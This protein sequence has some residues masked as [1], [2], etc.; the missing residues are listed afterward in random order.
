MT[1]VQV[2]LAR[3]LYFFA[4][5]DGLIDTDSCETQTAELELDGRTYTV[6]HDGD[7]IAVTRDDGEQLDF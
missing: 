6:L 7:G 4:T 1:P 2:T 3:L 5:E